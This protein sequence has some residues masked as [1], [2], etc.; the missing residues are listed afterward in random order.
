MNKSNH[1]YAMKTIHPLSAQYSSTKF[2]GRG[3]GSYW[4]GAYF[5]FWP[6]GGSGGAN[7]RIDRNNKLTF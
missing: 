4:R 6:I 7:S 1:D 5:K 2:G 3:G